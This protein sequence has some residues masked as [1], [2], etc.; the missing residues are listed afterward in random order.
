M[1]A[2][3][4]GAGRPE[5][6]LPPRDPQAYVIEIDE[7]QAGLVS[8]RGDERFFTFISAAS[9]F[10]A[11]EG[12]RFATPVAAERAARQLASPRRRA[13]RFTS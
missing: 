1:N 11:L 4:S 13:G 8:R 7:T 6:G 10:D 3:L 2:I 12:H 9:A 5:Q